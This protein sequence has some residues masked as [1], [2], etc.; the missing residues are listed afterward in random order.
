MKGCKEK[1]MPIF[2]GFA[3]WGEI[4]HLFENYDIEPD[5][6]YAAL[7][8]ILHY[9]GCANVLFKKNDL[10]YW[11]Y[12][13]HCSC[14]GL[15]RQWDP[16]EYKTKELFIE[17]IKKYRFYDGPESDDKNEAFIKQL[18]EMID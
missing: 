8:D 5:Q 14:Y 16:E 12:G 1:I 18:I 4:C 7:Y 3:S 10:Y 11:A 2:D 13:S 15:E 6:L 17:A 9:D